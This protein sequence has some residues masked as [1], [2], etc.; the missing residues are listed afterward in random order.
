MTAISVVYLLL[1]ASVQTFTRLSHWDLTLKTS[2]HS[3]CC[4]GWTRPRPPWFWSP[5]SMS[6]AF[7]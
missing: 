4:S 3:C 1:Q 2:T 5:S 6:S 7:P